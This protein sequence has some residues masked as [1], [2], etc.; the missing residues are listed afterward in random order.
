MSPPTNNLNRAISHGSYV[1]HLSVI[2]GGP[3]VVFASGSGIICLM[4]G[5]IGSES[6]HG[7]HG[8]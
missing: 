8:C 6:S 7:Q 5:R 3:V 2:V 1:A 4:Q